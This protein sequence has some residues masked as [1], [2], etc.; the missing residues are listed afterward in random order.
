MRRVNPLT[1]A[2]RPGTGHA[3]WTSLLAVMVMLGL[4]AVAC[5]ADEPTPTV[6]EKEVLTTVEVPREVGSLTI[7]SGRSESLVDPII[8]QFADATGIDVKVKYA[9]T[10]QLAAT[11]LEEGANS[12][13]DIFFAQDP[14]GLG[15]VEEMLSTLPA[16]ILGRVPDWARSPN[17]KWVGISGRAR[18]LVY[19]P[20]NLTEADLPDDIWDLTDPKW[21]GRLGWAPTNASFQTMVS[22]MRTLWGEEKT[23]QWLEGVLDNEPKLYPKNTPQVAAVADGEIDVGMVNHYYLF[24]FLAEKGDSF[25]ARNY[26]MRAGGPGALIMV[27]GTGI[28][29]TAKNRDNAERFLTFLLSKVGQ[30]YFTNETFEYPQVEGVRTQR[31]LVPRDQINA[32]AIALADMADLDGTQRMLRETGVLP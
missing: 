15:A 19:N 2:I 30:T 25:P 11:L 5:D 4:L 12:P 6:V 13:A 27:S 23:R 21:K 10:P 7:Y 1:H 32:P 24:R 28:L 9:S 22:A 31:M 18:T 29:S 26:H 20:N 8:R 3:L 17:G 14:G 16:E